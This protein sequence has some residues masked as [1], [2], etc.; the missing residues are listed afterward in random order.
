MDV[1]YIEEEMKVI[2]L[3]VYNK[4]VKS[5]I[6]LFGR[7]IVMFNIMLLSGVNEIFFF[8]IY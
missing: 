8:I 5:V 7:Y 3:E 6:V 1:V 2:V 4:L